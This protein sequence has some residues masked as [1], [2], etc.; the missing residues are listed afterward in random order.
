L[1]RISCLPP[2]NLAPITRSGFVAVV[3]KPN[4][5]KSTLLNRLIGQKLAITS[6]KPQS[7]RDR[8]T[9]ILTDDEG[10]IVLV[11]TPGLIEPGVKLQQIMRATAVR[12]LHDADAI[13]YLVEADD[14]E[15]PPEPIERLAGLERRP[16]APV[17]IGRTKADL[18]SDDATARLRERWP[19]HVLLS[20]VTGDGI[21]EL[22]RRLRAV[23]PEGPPLFPS[24]D[25]STQHLRF[26]AA[27]L[28]RETALEQLGD[29]VPHALACGI[30]EFR[31]DRSPVY[32]RAIL[33]VERESQKR[34]VI[35]HKGSR[36]RELGSAARLKI[37]ELLSSPVF[38]DL[39]VKVLPNW[40]RDQDALR[41]LGY[42]L[43]EVPRS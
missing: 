25:V 26:F 10:Q 8:I 34:I 22:Q 23:L 11:D 17:I 40:R 16:A 2:F 39:W 5:G 13:L 28:I 32:I 21:E 7:T 36:I 37:E 42:V 31:E 12:A 30:E 38:L 24:D 4:V 9:G 15:R 41:R 1:S 14:G 43:P 35:G 3:G 6:P 18:L 33:Y 20:S 27:E 29:E 19:D